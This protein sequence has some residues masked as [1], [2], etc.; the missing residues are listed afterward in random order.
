M[1]LSPILEPE[2]APKHFMNSIMIWITC[3]YQ[4]VMLWFV[5]L[6]YSAL[7]FD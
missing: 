5:S 7:E 2:D 6:C 1:V 3:W 4:Q